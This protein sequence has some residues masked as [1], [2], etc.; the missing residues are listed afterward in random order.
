MRTLLILLLALFFLS[1]KTYIATK[2][3]LVT[4]N[5]NYYT[6][7]ITFVNDSIMFY[8]KHRN[9]N[10]KAPLFIPYSGTKI[11]YQS[12]DYR[13]SNKKNLYIFEK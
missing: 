11:I 1:C 8:E 6:D 13:K 4:K 9:G 7:K 5:R 10:P 3:K 2:Y 12:K